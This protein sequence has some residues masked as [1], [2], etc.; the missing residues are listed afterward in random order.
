MILMYRKQFHLDSLNK[1]LGLK[2]H[3]PFLL[4]VQLELLFGADVRLVHSV[5]PFLLAVTLISPRT[6]LKQQREKRH[7]HAQT[8][9]N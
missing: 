8:V 9:T 1:L 6:G 7:N 5:F 4:V 3:K 2:G